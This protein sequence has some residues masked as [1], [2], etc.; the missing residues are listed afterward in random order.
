MNMNKKAAAIKGGK[1]ILCGVS[2]PLLQLLK[3]TR[4]DRILK[5]AKDQKEATG[6]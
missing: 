3:I 2:P 5:I 1:C 6:V 4:L